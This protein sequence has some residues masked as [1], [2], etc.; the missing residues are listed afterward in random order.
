MVFSVLVFGQRPDALALM[1][2]TVIA[3]AGLALTLPIFRAQWL[4]MQA[5]RDTTG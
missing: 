1:G 2:I 5:S 3:G 4:A